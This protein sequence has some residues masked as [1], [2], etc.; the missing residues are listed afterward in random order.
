MSDTPLPSGNLCPA[1][2]TG[3]PISRLTGVIRAEEV[4]EKI[5]TYGSGRNS[6]LDLLPPTWLDGC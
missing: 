1:G 6:I 3:I 2:N 4:A 5:G